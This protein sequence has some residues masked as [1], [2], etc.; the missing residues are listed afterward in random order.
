MSAF[1]HGEGED[2]VQTGRIPRRSGADRVHDSPS[3]DTSLAPALQSTKLPRV[4]RKGCATRGVARGVASSA[5][6]A[7]SRNPASIRALRSRRVSGQNNLRADSNLV[8]ISDAALA[9]W[10]QVG[11]DVV[12]SVESPSKGRGLRMTLATK[13][14]NSPSVGPSNVFRHFRRLWTTSWTMSAV[15]KRA[16]KRG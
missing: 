9:G 2:R 14:T 5:A 13:V 1:L 11:S 7:P 15:R 16:A 4:D 8:C 10:A 6:S 3:A 12:D